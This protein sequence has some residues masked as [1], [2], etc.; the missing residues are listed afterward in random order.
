MESRKERSRNSCQQEYGVRLLDNNALIIKEIRKVNLTAYSIRIVYLS[1]IIILLIQ[2]IPV[3]AIA[4]I[5]STGIELNQNDR[6]LVWTLRYNTRPI[7]YGKL[8]TTIDNVITSTLSRALS[9][10]PGKDRW[11]DSVDN[12]LS[13]SYQFSDQLNAGLTLGNNWA[14]DM[15]LKNRATTTR[16][17]YQFNTTMKPVKQ[18]TFTQTVGQMIDERLSK[19]DDGISFGSIINT[20]LPFTFRRTQ[21]DQELSINHTLNT[22]KRKMR[23]S[24]FDWSLNRKKEN[25]FV[26]GIGMEGDY[27]NLGYFSDFNDTPIEHRK[28]NQES[29]LLTL[30][31]RSLYPGDFSIE[32]TIIIQRGQVTDTANEKQGSRKY[33]DNSRKSGVD[34]S[35]RMD[36]HL[37]ERFHIEMS[38]LL[39][40][41]NTRVQNPIRSRKTK[42]LDLES[43]VSFRIFRPDSIQFRGSLNR[44]RIDTPDGV[45]NDRDEFKGQFWISYIRHI[46]DIGSFWLTFNTIQTHSVNLNMSQAGSNKWVRTYLL[47]PAVQLHPIE[48]LQINHTVDLYSSRI[49]FDFDNTLQPQSNITRRWSSLTQTM[50]TI[51]D[52]TLLELDFYLE[53]N[54]YGKWSS[55]QKR[56]PLEDGIRRRAGFQLHHSVT[57]HFWFKPGYAYLIRRE[58]NIVK[59]TVNR[60]DI[61]KTFTLQFE[62]IPDM[63]NTLSLNATRAIRKTIRYPV[64]I[65]DMIEAKYT[66]LF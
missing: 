54:D 29:F 37:L 36:F 31:K 23:R 1:T 9:G 63:R 2:G 44:I 38:G 25:S 15:L 39:S 42:E 20:E 66:R 41:D 64:R 43:N 18:L 40:E 51:T 35:T 22:M 47:S 65:R 3:I 48:E 53:N 28:R 5:H 30:G 7:T 26:V 11:R 52:V 57:P 4:E 56:I 50:I 61:D 49:E 55:H 17:F 12:N 62:Y 6:D 14:H 16:T 45:L 13:L 46:Q 24:S 34:L 8:T 59:K 58:N 27:E 60:R 33:H 32:N 21:W 19:K 10:Y